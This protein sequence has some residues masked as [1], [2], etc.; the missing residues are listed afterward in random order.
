MI[1]SILSIGQERPRRAFT[2]IEL[3]IVIAIIAI[4][5]LI[6]LPNFLEAQIRAKVSRSL[7]D[8]RSIATAIEAY[9][10]DYSNEP[11]VNRAEAMEAQIVTDCNTQEGIDPFSSWW[12]F[13]SPTLTTPV[14]YIT[15]I[16]TM[17]F[18]DTYV[19]GF[20]KKLGYT[21]QNQPYTIIR[22]TATPAG[23]VYPAP[24]GSGLSGGWGP[25]TLTAAAG[26]GQF[27][28]FYRTA[29]FREACRKAG[30]VIYTA[31][32]DGKDSTVWGAPEYYD[33][34]N[35][36]MSFGDIYYFGSGTPADGDRCR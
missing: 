34:T 10:V 14:A 1:R 25:A 30:Y 20:A 31:G 13:V 23:G 19:F 28:G 9:V 21:K 33:P 4:L 5:A 27:A 6:A 26:N 36:T 22:N 29:M 32:P 2:L 17:P 8:M 3:L 35:G 12:G 16:P 11:K 7:S 15:A 24:S 18:F